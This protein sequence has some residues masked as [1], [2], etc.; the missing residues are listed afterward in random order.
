MR[1]LK[2]LYGVTPISDFGPM[3]L[4]AVR[5]AMVEAGWT[6]GFIN[7]SVDR[8]RKFFRWGS[9]PSTRFWPTGLRHQTDR[10]GKPSLRNTS[11]P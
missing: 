6:R 4:K 9:T 8:I 3:A 11:T 7:K 10:S 5:N 2:K 1:P